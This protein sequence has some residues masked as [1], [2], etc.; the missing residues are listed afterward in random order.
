MRSV[1]ASSSTSR[2]R[3]VWSGWRCMDARPAPS[4]PATC[5]SSTTASCA[6]RAM[7]TARQSS[8][9]RSPSSL[10]A[11]SEA[12]KKA[13]TTSGANRQ[14]KGA[15]SSISASVMVMGGR[16]SSRGSRRTRSM[17]PRLSTISTRPRGK[18]HSLYRSKARSPSRAR[19]AMAL[20]R[21]SN[22]VRRSRARRWLAPRTT[23]SGPGASGGDRNSATLASSSALR[24]RSAP[25]RVR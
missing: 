5:A 8:G 16:A 18:E 1:S 3:A 22:S 15:P 12:A 2:G 20:P 11:A 13:G 9:W 7:D 24:A 10:T 6:M 23:K 21:F 17:P 25:E 4:G 19:T 14:R